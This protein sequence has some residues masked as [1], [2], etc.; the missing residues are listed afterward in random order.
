LVDAYLQDFRSTVIDKSLEISLDSDKDY[1]D[2][3]YYL[4]LNALLDGCYAFEKLEKGEQRQWREL[5]F[6][7]STGSPVPLVVGL[8]HYLT[9]IMPLVTKAYHMFFD[10][11]SNRKTITPGD[12]KGVDVETIRHGIYSDTDS[13]VTFA[14]RH[15]IYS[16]TDSNVTFVEWERSKCLIYSVLLFY[17]ILLICLIFVKILILVF[18]IH[19]LFYYIMYF[20]N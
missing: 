9:I 19:V 1:E 14:L 13:N 18:Y 17:L 10:W 6:K 11:Y 20:L 3:I 12:F 8:S 5:L 4:M 15:G 16:D 7:S 2:N